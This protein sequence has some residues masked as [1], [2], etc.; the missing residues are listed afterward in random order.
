ML[1]RALFSL[2]A[3]IFRHSVRSVSEVSAQQELVSASSASAMS[4][5]LLAD[6]SSS[7]DELSPGFL[8]DFSWLLGRC[9]TSGSFLRSSRGSISF[10]KGMLAGK[11]LEGF[12]LYAIGG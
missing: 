9:V 1:R 6:P 5:L 10:G 12:L 7:L 2:A 11:I 3:C 4:S 8:V